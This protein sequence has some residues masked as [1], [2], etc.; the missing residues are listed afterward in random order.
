MPPFPASESPLP[1]HPSLFS[2]FPSL[3]AGEK[4]VLDLRV[5]HPPLADADPRGPTGSPRRRKVESPSAPH[6]KFGYEPD[7]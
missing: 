3:A 5:C 7:L 6:P 1:K 4:C 2:S